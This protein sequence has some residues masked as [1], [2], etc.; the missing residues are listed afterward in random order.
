M[1][2][3]RIALALL[4]MSCNALAQTYVISTLH[5]VFLRGNNDGHDDKVEVMTGNRR[6]PG[7]GTFW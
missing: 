5:G 7:T 3:V 1:S 2:S 4:T 6:L